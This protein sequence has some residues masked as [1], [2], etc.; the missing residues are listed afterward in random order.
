MEDKL[1]N[2][3]QDILAKF[4]AGEANLEEIEI[5][6]N[7][8][9]DSDENKDEFAKF[10]KTWSA[11]SMQKHFSTNKGWKS[12]DKRISNKKIIL[13]ISSFIA[14]AS[15][16][17]FILLF[18]FKETKLNRTKF[19]NNAS[20][21]VNKP[22][23][24]GSKIK[25]YKNSSIKYHYNKKQNKRIAKLKGKAF[26]SIKRNVKRKFVV[27]TKFGQVEVLGTK[28]KVTE[29]SNKNILVDVY[30][31]KVKLSFVKSKLDTI[32]K[33]LTNSESAIMNLKNKSIINKQQ[34]PGAFFDYNKSLVFKNHNLNFIANELS[35][36]YKVDIKLGTNVNHNLSFTST[37]YN[38]SI[39]EILNVLCQT[40]NLNYINKENCYIIE[41]N[42]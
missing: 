13:K 4:L 17:A 30:S 9:D 26:F 37:F 33:I 15:I 16:I 3:N 29:L 5:V 31:G 41:K 11:T 34:S 32:S 23:P 7:W 40:L 21:I 20:K 1:Q 8:I 19:V 24:D 36:F 42:E 27:Q 18:N 25:L 38:N 6:A 39:E 22:L 35:K 12:I 2:I 14:A 10:Q 28:F